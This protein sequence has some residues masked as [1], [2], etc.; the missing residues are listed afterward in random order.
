MSAKSQ[1]KS[2]EVVTRAACLRPRRPGSRPTPS[3]QALRALSG[4]PPDGH[5]TERENALA[6]Q[7]LV[8][9]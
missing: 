3:T 7:I 2:G 1:H 4:P 5:D 6:G 9:L 8:P